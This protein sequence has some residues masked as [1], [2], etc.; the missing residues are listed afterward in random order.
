MK[1]R[2]LK[3]STI[4]NRGKELLTFTAAAS[5][6]ALLGA[7]SAPQ[8]MAYTATHDFSTDD[9]QRG[10]WGWTA[11]QLP[12]IICTSCTP[13]IDKKTGD[14]L[15][16][17]EHVF[18]FEVVDF[19]G[20]ADKVLDWDWMEGF[21]GNFVD[22]D[23]QETGLAVANVDTSVFKVKYPMG[24]W[25]EGLGANSVKASTEHYSVMEHVL[26]CFET[27]PYMYAD[28]VTGE[29]GELLD[30]ETGAFV[31][32]CSIGALD[33]ALMEIV[34]GL[35]I[36]PLGTLPDGTP[37][38]PPNESTILND[39]AVSNDYSITKKDDGKVLYRFG[40]AVKRPID[41]RMYARMPLPAEWK[42]PNA[43]YQVTSAYLTV[44]HTLTNNP[45][46]RSVRR[47]WR[48]RAPGAINPVTP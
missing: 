9:V 42:D 48:T 8:A 21:A 38:I 36:G 11:A 3:K 25:L 43:N 24:T 23:T 40:T 12:G 35:P 17:V 45:N 34:D 6:V 7:L 1:A 19:V 18:G 26:S 14:A 44:K 15:Y 22:A 33:D 41:M 37:D 2:H 27:L 16:P 31:A 10:W 29:Q 4:R 30:P 39:I 28:P 47:T 32:D 13:M 20:A 46:D 5:T